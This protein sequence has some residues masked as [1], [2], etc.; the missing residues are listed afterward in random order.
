MSPFSK[1]E[2]ASS[3]H[4]RFMT[5]HA[6]GTIEPKTWDENPFAPVVDG[7]RLAHAA[8]TDSY[9]GGI[10][11]EAAFH[12]VVIYREGT[13]Y[14]ADGS[15]DYR[16]ARASFVGLQR[17]VGRLGGRSGSFALEVSGTSQGGITTASWVVAPGSGTG[18]LR[19]LRGTGGFAYQQGVTSSTTLDYDLSI[20]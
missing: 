5:I 10:E 16:T 6:K 15:V 18:E 2:E 19:G 17:V 13:A 3:I 14:L 7:P 4:A 9:H 11:G 20:G 1:I 12:Y 8:G